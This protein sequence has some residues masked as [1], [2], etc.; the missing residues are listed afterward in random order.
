MVA[1][2][3]V[4]AVVES[5]TAGTEGGGVYSSANLSV[6]AT[7]FGAP[8]VGSESNLVHDVVHQLDSGGLERL[9]YGDQ[10]TFNCF[11]DSGCNP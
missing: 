9:D 5:N 7:D 8:G 11:P 6:Q 3:L 2:S 1:C 4:S 10:A